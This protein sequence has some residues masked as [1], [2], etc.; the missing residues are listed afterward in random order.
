MN[1]TLF[2]LS[3]GPL[4]LAKHAAMRRLKTG[5]EEELSPR[6]AD[7]VPLKWS[8]PSLSYS[9]SYMQRFRP[10]EMRLEEKRLNIVPLS[11]DEEAFASSD[12]NCWWED[13]LDRLRMVKKMEDDEQELRTNLRKIR[14]AFEMGNEVLN[15][16]HASHSIRPS[17]IIKEETHF[18]KK[19][20]ESIMSGI[21]ERKLS[22]EMPDAS[23]ARLGVLA[24]DSKRSTP[25]PLPPRLSDSST[26]TKASIKRLET[27]PQEQKFDSSK[28]SEEQ[29]DTASN[30]E[31]SEIEIKSPSQ[32]SG[33]ESPNP[34]GTE[35]R[36]QF[37]DQLPP[38][39]SPEFLAPTIT[40]PSEATSTRSANTQLPSSSAIPTQERQSPF[41]LKSPP[42]PPP[43]PPPT[44]SSS[45]EPKFNLPS[46]KPVLPAIAADVA[47]RKAEALRRTTA[48]SGPIPASYIASS[49]GAPSV[50]YIDELSPSG[51]MGGVYDLKNPSAPPPASI[52][53]TSAIVP[54]DSDEAGHAVSVSTEDLAVRPVEAE[55]SPSPGQPGKGPSD[56]PEPASPS[57][58]SDVPAKAHVDAS[59]VPPSSTEDQ[60][61]KQ[62]MDMSG[63]GG[64]PSDASA[65]GS[66][67][68]KRSFFGLLRKG[69]KSKG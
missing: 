25:P 32:S 24:R 22:Q 46:D 62:S 2:M 43:P 21:R 13:R 8:I 69:K 15:A 31:K 20:P 4:T 57:Q 26:P 29:T 45:A 40:A 17:V 38:P 66:H 42:P 51:N 44:T 11:E 18:G 28:R 36:V 33:L 54:E 10:L 41:S 63:S 39:P 60:S 58:D 6:G 1:S 61:S 53:N 19:L 49:S 23:K 37:S 7:S 9:T 52:T 56:A 68:K 12:F 48:T 5:G 3:I 55:V 14:M 16:F 64:E 35:R 27:P 59:L 47:Q 67:H 34:V 30:K 50:T 65:T